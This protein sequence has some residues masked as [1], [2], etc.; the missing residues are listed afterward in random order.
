MC[1]LDVESISTDLLN[2]NC[3][4][5]RHCFIESRRQILVFVFHFADLSLEPLNLVTEMEMEIFGIIEFMY[6]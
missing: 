1:P 6:N 2:V 4:T 5:T 3:G